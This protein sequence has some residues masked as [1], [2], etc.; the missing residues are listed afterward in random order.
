MDSPTA[1]ATLKVLCPACAH[2]GQAFG[3]TVKPEQEEMNC[4]NCRK[5]FT[6]LTRFVSEARGQIDQF[7]FHFYEVSTIEEGGRLRPRTVRTIANTARI[8]PRTWVTIVYRAGR[9]LGISDQTN[10]TW[11]DIPWQAPLP[12]R[13]PR[14][15]TASFAAVVLL[16]LLYLAK[17]F[18]QTGKAIH[19]ERSVLVGL[20][21]IAVA[22]LLPLFW[23]V[24]RAYNEE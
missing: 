20:V 18:S 8:L 19:Q 1:P 23:W 12:P 21:V 6:L 2:R 17:W 24:F 3:I 11:W 15:W 4:P 22:A 14:V 9:E 5:R 10:G 7:G 16:A 13:H